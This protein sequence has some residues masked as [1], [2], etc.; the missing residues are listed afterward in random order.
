MQVAAVPDR[1]LLIDCLAPLTEPEIARLSAATW[2]GRTPVGCV[3]YHDNLT[4]PEVALILAAG[5]GLMTVGI[6]RRDAMENP[7]AGLGARDGLTAVR[8]LKAL[9]I[10]K[11]V[12]NWLDVEG[13]VGASGDQ[14]VAYVNAADAVIGLWTESGMYDGWAEPLSAADL[15]RRLTVKRYWA[16]SPKTPAPA[17]RGFG[18]VQLVED[19]LLAGVRVDVDEH[20]VDLLGDSCHWLVAG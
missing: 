19:I 15:Y 1:A 6:A 14:V 8:N 2:Q 11:G 3:R 4:E 13:T 5:W 7:S 18:L 10:P 12:T 20:R 16:S 9:S 17:I